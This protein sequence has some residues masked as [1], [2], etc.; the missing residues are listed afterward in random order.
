[1]LLCGIP[2]LQFDV[3]SSG[4]WAMWFHGRAGRTLNPQTLRCT[5]TLAIDRLPPDKS[6]GTYSCRIKE[7]HQRRANVPRDACI[8]R[9]K[10]V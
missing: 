6:L 10:T 1:M 8:M 7:A 9:R 2:M 4:M 5:R 3:D